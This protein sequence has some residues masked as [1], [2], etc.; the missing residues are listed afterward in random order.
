MFSTTRLAPYGS[1][2]LRLALGLVF[3]AHALL[4]L[5]VFTL[6]GT[7]AWFA[8]Q[9]FPGWT[10]YPVFAAE[11]IGALLLFTGFHSRTA[12]LALVPV[13]LGALKVHAANGWAFS[14][15][16]GG[17]EY[18]VL[19]IVLLVTHAL[20]GPG[21]FAVASRSAIPSARQPAPLS[22]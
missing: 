2:V 4:K 8:A 1:L 20:L 11:L 18:P 6:P 13:M 5:V 17:W 10:A 22:G 16:N 19:L 9:G 15:P 3:L 14:A 21:P 12:A 7:A